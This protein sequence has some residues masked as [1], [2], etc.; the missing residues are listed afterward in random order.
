[1]ADDFDVQQ[2]SLITNFISVTGVDRERAIFFLQSSAWN[3]EVRGYEFSVW[4]LK[5]T[6]GFLIL[7]FHTCKFC[8]GFDGS[9]L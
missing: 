8:P 6:A 5:S 4:G 2:E 7:H 3:L 9:L 1:M